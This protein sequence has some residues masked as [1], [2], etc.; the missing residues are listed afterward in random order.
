MLEAHRKTCRAEWSS[1]RN[2][3]PEA[4]ASSGMNRRDHRM[5]TRRCGGILRGSGTG[6]VRGND[7]IS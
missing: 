7:Y 6:P 3:F 4:E 2:V 5:A 1:T